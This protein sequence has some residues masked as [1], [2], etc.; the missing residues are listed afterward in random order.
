MVGKFIGEDKSMGFRNGQIYRFRTY[1]SGDYIVLKEITGKWCP[2]GS[3]E[4]LLENWV[5]LR[6]GIHE[7][8]R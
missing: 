4:K 8:Y 5:I 3:V 2:Y 6:E 7:K 1:L